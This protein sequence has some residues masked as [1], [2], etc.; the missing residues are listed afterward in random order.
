MKK[1]DGAATP[2]QP[3]KR[4]PRRMSVS[5]CLSICG[6][7]ILSF[8]FGAAVMVYEVPPSHFLGKALIGARAWYERSQ[9]SSATAD[10]DPAPVARGVIDEP[11]RTFDGFTLYASASLEAPGTRVYLMNMRRKVVHQWGVSFSQVWPVSPLLPGGVRDDLVCIFGCHLYPNGDLLA[12]FQ[13]LEQLANGLGLVKLD[14]DSQV[15]WKYAAHVHHDVDVGEDGTIYAIEHELTE[16][17]PKGLEFIPTP[18]LVDRLILISP[19]GKLKKSI[20][21][22]ESFRDSPYSALLASLDRVGRNPAA[23]DGLT[24]PRFDQA[25]LK[26]DALHTNFVQVLSREL[27]PRFP[28]FKAGQ[29]LISLRHLDTIAVM[30]VEKGTVVWAARGPWQAQHDPQ[31]LEN[32]HLLIFDN[33]G[34]PRGSRVLE[35]DPQTQAFPWSYSGEHRGPFYTSERGMSQRLPNGNTLIVDSEGG[36]LL[37]VT[38]SKD[39]V[40]SFL[41]PADRHSPRG[42]RFI[43]TARRY[44]P[45]QLHFLKEGE[46]ARP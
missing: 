25:V 35:Y 15:I 26:E 9:V 28:G 6:L 23:S 4:S 30:D 20:P 13:G 8:V 45:D 22:L 10:R 12:V 2:N 19:E 31:F 46:H 33:R 14:K 32:G 21:I 18:C 1:D 42:R 36:E 41:S 34:L 40:W 7:I 5:R 38:Q 16:A 11:G 43:T 37:E 17:M 29:V 27:A 39:V 24:G 3:L 44:S